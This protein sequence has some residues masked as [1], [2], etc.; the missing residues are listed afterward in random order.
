MFSVEYQSG[1]TAKPVFMSLDLE[2]P[3]GFASFLSNAS[4]HRKVFIPSTFNMSSIL[5]SVHRQE[6]VDL[7]CDKDFYEVELPGPV[8]AEYKE[9]CSSVKSVI[10]AGT[11]STKSTIFD[12]SA[13]IIDPLTL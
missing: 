8:A 10:V 13:N 5:K 7:V 12:A 4:N 3:L 1:Q 11:G 6:S 9:K 2:S